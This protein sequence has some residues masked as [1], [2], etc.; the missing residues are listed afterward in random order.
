M[1]LSGISSS[2]RSRDAPATSLSSPALRSVSSSNP[3]LGITRDSIPRAVPANVISRVG[4]P[5]Q[6]LARDRDARIEVAARS[7]AGDHHA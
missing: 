1:P 7:P 4:P 2:P 6:Q 3:S 5:A